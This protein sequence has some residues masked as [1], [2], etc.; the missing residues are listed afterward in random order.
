MDTPPLGSRSS[1]PYSSDSESSYETARTERSSSDDSRAY[2]SPRSPK[3]NLHVAQSDRVTSIA[4]LMQEDLS[5]AEIAEKLQATPQST[6]QWMP[7]GL[8]EGEFIKRAHELG[9]SQDEARVLASDVRTFVHSLISNAP[10][11]GVRHAE[12]VLRDAEKLPAFTSM[13][14]LVATNVVAG[15]AG[16]LTS[17]FLGK[18]F[19]NLLGMGVGSQGAWIFPIAGLLNVLVSEPVGGAIRMQGSFHPSVDGAAYTDYNTACARLAK[20]QTLQDPRGI[21]RWSKE[22]A[23]IVDGVIAREQANPEMMFRSGVK[24]PQRDEEGFALDHHGERD[25]HFAKEAEKVI[26]GARRRSLVT[27]ELPFNFYTVNYF[28]SGALA[29]YFRTLYSPDVASAIDILVSAGLGM[30][31]GAQTALLQDYLRNKIQ[32]APLRSLTENVKY[33]KVAVA[34]AKRDALVDSMNKARACETVLA[35][36]LASLQSA[37][38]DG[39]VLGRGGIKKTE[40][41]LEL[42]KDVRRKIVREHHKAKKHHEAHTAGRHR[43]GTEVGTLV[44]AYLGEKSAPPRPLQGRRAINRVIAKTIATPLALAFTPLYTAVVV[45]AITQTVSSLIDVSTGNLNGTHV[46]GTAPGNMTDFMFNTTA[47]PD[48]QGGTDDTLETVKMVL[49]A[50]FS[51]PLILGYMSRN[52]YIALAIERGITYL[53]TVCTGKTSGSDIEDETSASTS[54]ADDSDHSVVIDKPESTTEEDAVSSVVEIKEDDPEEDTS[55]SSS[56]SS[57][58]DPSESSM[59]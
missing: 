4:H 17:F 32:K 55:R 8:S 9:L 57:S 34:A 33:A 48:G 59:T 24:K 1:S 42:A 6:T 44:N 30:I 58:P 16:Y 5:T 41:D 35:E 43:F 26:T 23:R 46:N 12:Q 36:R 2:F 20:A 21:Q 28:F 39:D 14:K 38:D 49:S 54:Q 45:P 37:A 56:A 13:K 18:L 15:A 47:V 19:A 27:D 31:S 25:A 53:E 40:A 51:L 22:I 11:E 10:A 7:I 52:Q 50:G 29:P 3:K